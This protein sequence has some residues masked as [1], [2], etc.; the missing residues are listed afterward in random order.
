MDL[1][2]FQERLGYTFKDEAMLKTALT[3]TSYANENN[4]TSYE[5]LEFLGDAVLQLLTSKY[6]YNT[7]PDFSEGKMSKMRANIVC[8]ET[9]FQIAEKLDIGSC[10]IL[11]KGEEMT[12]G[13]HRASVLA[14][15]VEATLAAIY[16]DGGIEKAQEII[17]DAY[18]HI[19]DKA[20][21]GE[22]NKDYKTAL[23]EKLQTDGSVNIEY[24]LTKDEGP[25]HDKTFFMQVSVNGTVL[26][27][28]EGKTKQQAQ[29]QAAKNALEGMKNG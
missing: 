21:R 13:R 4:T 15:M 5:R 12:G 28:G 24:T 3:H 9:L 22:L 29:Q 8:E 19:I 10:A 27:Q 25:A 11:G 7:Y 20:A 17:F 1:K 2:N 26:G 6:I 16:L 14:D 18:G 23:Q